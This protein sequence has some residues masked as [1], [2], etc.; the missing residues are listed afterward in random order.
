MNSSF[1]INC[2]IT[3]LAFGCLSAEEIRKISVKEINV[4]ALFDAIGN[5]V[6]GGPYDAA[7][8]PLSALE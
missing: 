1:P 4:A 6:E 7:L 5:P 2:E 8:G 3:S